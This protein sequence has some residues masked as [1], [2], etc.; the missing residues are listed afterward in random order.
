M[1]PDAGRRPSLGGRGRRNR[2][3]GPEGERRDRGDRGFLQAC[4][5]IV[6]QLSSLAPIGSARMSAAPDRCG[7]PDAR[8]EWSVENPASMSQKNGGSAPFATQE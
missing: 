6:L 4:V 5:H 1:M 7:V 2:D 3:A 8:E